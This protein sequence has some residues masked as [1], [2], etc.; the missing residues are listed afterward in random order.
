MVNILV[1]VLDFSLSYLPSIEGSKAA[2]RILEHSCCPIF[3]SFNFADL[4]MPFRKQSHSRVKAGL[5][6]DLSE[7]SWKTSV[8]I[9]V[10][11]G[12]R[13]CSLRYLSN[14]KS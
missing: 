13:D 1:G 5:L 8:H 9:S 4:P 10:V 3:E 12:R 2:T 6:L 7:A 11:Y 14:C